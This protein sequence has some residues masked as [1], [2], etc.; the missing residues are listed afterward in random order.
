MG[1]AVIC[2]NRGGKILFVTG[3]GQHLNPLTAPHRSLRLCCSCWCNGAEPSA[4]GPGC[5]GHVIPKSGSR[6]FDSQK[7]AQLVNVERNHKPN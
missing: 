2:C 5:C 6:K 1:C 4:D 7:L 3:P